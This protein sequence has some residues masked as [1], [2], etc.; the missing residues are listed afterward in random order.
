MQPSLSVGPPPSSSSLSVAPEDWMVV[1]AGQPLFAAP[2]PVEPPE[3]EPPEEPLDP[4]DPEEP[5]EPDDPPPP[6]VTT[7][8]FGTAAGFLLTKTKA[9]MFAIS[10]VL[11]LPL[12]GDIGN[13][14]FFLAESPI[15]E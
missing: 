5:E 3:V 6:E 9:A 14:Y 7:V 4:E 10:A 2:P 15:T 13:G 11:S 1:P 8:P 12:N